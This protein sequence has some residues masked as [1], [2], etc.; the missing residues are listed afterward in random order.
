MRGVFLLADMARITW[1][2]GGNERGLVEAENFLSSIT[3]RQRR[4]LRKAGK[5]QGF[6]PAVVDPV[7][8]Q[9]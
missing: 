5:A 1:G 2:V 6:D 7:T 9:R 4:A 3:Y 8:P